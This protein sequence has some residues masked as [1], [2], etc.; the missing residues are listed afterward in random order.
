MMRRYSKEEHERRGT[1]LYQQQI[2]PQVEP[3]NHG[4]IVAIDVDAGAFAVDDDQLRA[5][6]RLFELNPD[7]QIWC[8]RIGHDVMC[9]MRFFCEASS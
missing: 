8:E 1:E 9:H 2:R 3:E 7:A 4:R 5:C 6:E